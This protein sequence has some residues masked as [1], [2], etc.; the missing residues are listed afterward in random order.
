MKNK[1]LFRQG[2]LLIEIIDAI[3]NTASRVDKSGH[4]RIVLA[5]GEATGHHHSLDIDAADWWKSEDGTQFLEMVKSKP[6][7]HQE[8]DPIP[9]KR[10]QV[11]RVSRQREYAPMAIR[12]VQD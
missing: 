9:M 3:P 4:E 6:I 7:I 1:N 12:N 11:A 5:H 8:H 2:D 10:G